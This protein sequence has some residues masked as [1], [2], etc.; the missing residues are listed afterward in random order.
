[1]KIE[2]P[3]RCDVSSLSAF[4]AL[5][6]VSRVP[7][8]IWGHPGIGKTSVVRQYAE[9]TGQHCEVII[10]SLYEPPDIVGNV[11]LEPSDKYGRIQRHSVP[12][13]LVRILEADEKGRSSIV[14]FD[15]IS[16]CMLETQAT[17]L[18]IV[19]ERMAAGIKIPD[20]VT[21]VAASN[22]PDSSAGFYM[23]P[24]LA[25]R[26]MHIHVDRSTGR[27]EILKDPYTRSFWNLYVSG[28]TPPQMMHTIPVQV[29]EIPGIVF[30]TPRTEAF[31]RRV[32]AA[33]KAAG[34][35]DEWFLSTIKRMTIGS[36]LSGDESLFEMLLDYIEDSFK[37]KSD[38]RVNAEVIKQ[39]IDDVV[40]SGYVDVYVP[41]EWTRSSDRAVALAAALCNRPYDVTKSTIATQVVFENL[42][43]VKEIARSW[44]VEF[45]RSAINRLVA[46]S[47]E[48]F[49]MLY[50]GDEDGN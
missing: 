36:D 34:I 12:E 19:N 40:M 48:I 42:A 22:F 27:D 31:Y 24:A 2:I 26:F 7:L 8:L 21:F 41:I 47:E 37:G 4:I 20:S 33:T 32:R 1:M 50:G 11:Y 9:E 43:L 38:K 3:A 13:W 45:S 10:G 46:S 35:Y 39:K 18:R 6:Q 44:L 15:E 14:F 25:N 17:M 23:T 30:R 29:S 5:S 28:W 16:T 49:K